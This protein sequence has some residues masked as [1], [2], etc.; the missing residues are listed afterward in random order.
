MQLRLPPVPVRWAIGLL[1]F[2]AVFAWYTAPNPEPIVDA[3]DPFVGRW[4]VNG[5][6]SF[7]AEYSGSLTIQKDG[8]PYRLDWIITGSIVSGT[9]TVT[10]GVLSAEWESNADGRQAVGTAE[11][12]VDADMLVGTVRADGVEGAGTETGERLPGG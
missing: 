12:S 10:D 1:A 7:G 6:D 5:V 3:S 11:Y 2:V 9:G 8:D 4:L